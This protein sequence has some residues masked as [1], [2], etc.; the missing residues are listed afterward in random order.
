MGKK[1]VRNEQQQ[2]LRV[3][4]EL[5]EVWRFV[6]LARGRGQGD[7]LSHPSLSHLLWT[8][9]EY[10][11]II[12]S[13]LHPNPSLAHLKPLSGFLD[14]EKV[15]EDLPNFPFSP[16]VCYIQSEN[17][18]P[19]PCLPYYSP[20]LQTLPQIKLRHTKPLRTGWFGLQATPSNKK[21][22]IVLSMPFLT[23]SNSYPH[24]PPLP[25]QHIWQP[26][27]PGWWH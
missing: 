7:L 14:Q 22:L 18:P 10:Q 3:L 12:T 27:T 1:K 13:H 23:L 8:L 25:S 16:L 5:L 26:S 21:P 19:L 9:V 6:S 4:L 20:R 11:I 2:C 17:P 15:P 24:W